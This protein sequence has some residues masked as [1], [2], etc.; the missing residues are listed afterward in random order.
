MSDRVLVSFSRCFYKPS[1][2]RFKVFCEKKYNKKFSS[3]LKLL[4]SEEL[5]LCIGWGPSPKAGSELLLGMFEKIAFSEVSGRSNHHKKI[6]EKNKLNIMLGDLV[7]QYL[8]LRYGSSNKVNAIGQRL[9]SD[10]ISLNSKLG[11]LK[12]LFDYNE[13]GLIFKDTD[14]RLK[15]D[16]C[17]KKSTPSKEKIIVIEKIIENME[18][19]ESRPVVPS[20]YTEFIF[21]LI[22]PN[23][24]E[25]T[26]KSNKKVATVRTGPLATAILDSIFYVVKTKNDP[27]TRQKYNFATNEQILQKFLDN[28]KY[29]YVKISEKNLMSQKTFSQVI[30]KEFYTLQQ[31]LLKNFEWYEEAVIDSKISIFGSTTGKKIINSPMIKIIR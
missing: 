19:Y 14:L 16:N 26:I 27:A 29:K 30:T 17:F 7:L 8:E 12:I 25:L 22:S 21:K 2:E 1:L 24:G 4:K 28:R 5:E 15:F 3:Y 13:D 23:K 18:K 9:G 10:S 31:N 20:P 11:L 6:F